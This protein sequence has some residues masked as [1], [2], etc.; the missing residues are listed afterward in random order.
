MRMENSAELGTL[1][2]QWQLIAA[3]TLNFEFVRACIDPQGNTTNGIVVA[4][5]NVRYLGTTEDFFEPKLPAF[6]GTSAW[7]TDTYLNIW[8]CEMNILAAGHATLPWQRNQPPLPLPGGG[9]VDRKLLDGIILDYATVGNPSSSSYNN[10]G[11]L[12]TH[13]VGHWL[14]LFHLN[15]YGEPPTLCF[16]GDFVNDTPPQETGA[17][18]GCPSFP[19]TAN[20][21]CTQSP[22]GAM[23]MNYMAKTSDDCRIL[24]TAGQKTRMRSYFAQNGPAGTRYPY[25]QNY[26]GFKEFTTNPVIAQNNTIVVNFRNPMCLLVFLK[27]QMQLL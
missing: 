26:F 12:L 4:Q 22:L 6:G 16:P 17:Y 15:H 8:I 10:K 19:Q 20:N 7:P 2:T 1:P 13:E 5:T 27:A 11:R 25:I 21:S 23:F 9:S 24:F 14:G 18:Y 3:N